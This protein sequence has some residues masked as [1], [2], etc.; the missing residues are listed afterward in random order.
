MINALMNSPSWKDSVF[1]YSYDEG[2]GPLDH[3]APVPGHSND[4]TDAS[5]G[6]IPD[7]STDRSESGYILTVSGSRVPVAATCTAT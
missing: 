2:G 5:M 4:L 6:A 7:I 3:V 1:F